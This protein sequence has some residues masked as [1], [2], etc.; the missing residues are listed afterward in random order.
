MSTAGALV[1]LTF[2]AGFLLLWHRSPARRRSGI[3]ERLAPYLR[4]LPGLRIAATFGITPARRHWRAAGRA[5]ALRWGQWLDRAFGGS[6]SV[7]RRLIRAGSPITGQHFRAEQVVTGIAGG[8][9]GL[10]IGGLLWVRRDT[11]PLIAAMTP[12][13][14]VLAGVAGR[15]WLLSVQL[16]RR[17]QQIMTE[18]P[19]VADLLAL[20]LSAG[21]G[22]AAALERVCRLCRGELSRELG[23]ALGQARTGTPIATAL[24]GVADRTGLVALV[25]FVD[26]IVIALE[27]GTPLGD[28]VRAQAQDVREQTRREVI[29]AAGRK[30]IGMLIP[31]VFLILPV[32]V[33]FAL[34]PGFVA[35]SLT[36]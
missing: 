33:V 2:A 12:V 4:D 32:T 20:S 8:F 29:E 6:V 7:E 14:G 18:L 1:G 27:R 26:G 3:E 24:Q 25:R 10:L 34:F 21:E 36:W 31:V 16:R 35:L 5:A 11:V 30:E 15:D 22:T 9:V 13:L 23:V 17:E 19:T 28:V